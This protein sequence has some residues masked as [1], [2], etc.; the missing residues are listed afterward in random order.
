LRLNGVVARGGAEH[1]AR[2]PALS[3]SAFI[4][5]VDT[6]TSLIVPFEIWD[7]DTLFLHFGGRR[8]TTEIRVLH[9]DWEIE[10]GA[11]QQRRSGAARSTC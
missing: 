6:I 9:R 10:S 2:L 1:L 3:G 5:G 8:E 11:S 7:V 4:D